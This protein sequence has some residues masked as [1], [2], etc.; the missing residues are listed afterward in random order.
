MLGL[1]TV[2]GVLAPIR[3]RAAPENGKLIRYAAPRKYRIS[4]RGVVTGG[5]VPLS[6]L[7]MWLPVPQNQPEQEVSEVTTRPKVE[8]VPDVTGQAVVARRRATSGLPASG[9]TWSLEVSYEITCRQPRADWRAIR[10]TGMPDY[11]KDERYQMLTRP[12]KYLETEMAPIADQAARLRSQYH[13]PVE[14][15]RAAYLWVLER[16]EYKLVDGVGGA[17]FCMKNGHGECGD[18]SALLVAVLR[19]AGI[20]ARPVPGFWADQTNGWH[21]WAE[22]MLPTGDWLPVDAQVGDRNLWNRHHYFGSS[23]N[24]RVAVCKTMAIELTGRKVGQMKADFLQ[25]GAF[26]WYSRNARPGARKPS[27]TFTV[28]GQR[29]KEKT[30]PR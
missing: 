2:A 30:L 18:Y 7:E 19:A 21:V 27:A 6:S 16:T 17:A 1:G 24:R 12:E 5:A 14:L 20:P 23:D 8:L 15:A 10:Q 29:V 4:H 3:A 13:H 26:W 25:A 9:K 22:F 28:E 11:R